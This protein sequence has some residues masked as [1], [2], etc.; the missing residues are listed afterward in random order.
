MG[1]VLYIFKLGV[2]VW[3]L[4]RTYLLGRDLSSPNI[5]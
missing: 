2:I 1:V 4:K 5:F 3:G